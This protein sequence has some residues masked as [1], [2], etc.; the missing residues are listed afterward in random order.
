[1]DISG[2]ICTDH[3]RGCGEH[4]RCLRRT[5][6]WQGSSPRM[7]GA[8]K[9]ILDDYGDDRI[10]PADA[11]STPGCVHCRAEAEDHPRGCGEHWISF[12]TLF[13][14]PGSSPRMR[15][16]PMGCECGRIRRRI[17][18]AD[19][20]STSTSMIRPRLIGDHPRGCGE[21]RCACS[22]TRI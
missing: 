16:A 10:I 8:R 21:H 3:P 19:A 14:L 13:R 1:M 22:D 9:H 4:H 7:R 18:P 20:G 6:A 2:P 15:G 12:R 5:L 17:I 11:G